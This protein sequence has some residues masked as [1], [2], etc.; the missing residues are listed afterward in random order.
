MVS[1]VIVILKAPQKSSN[2][3]IVGILFQ[4][5]RAEEYRG[6]EKDLKAP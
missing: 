1:E 6:I 5:V 2:C 4:K 3:T